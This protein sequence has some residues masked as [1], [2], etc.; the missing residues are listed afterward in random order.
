MA[1]GGGTGPRNKKKRADGAATAQNG[2]AAA[3]GPTDTEA[4][5]IAEAKANKSAK[6][7]QKKV[8]KYLGA[9]MFVAQAIAPQDC[10][11]D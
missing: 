1:R 8:G 4:K 10:I 3:N 11:S 7:R 5:Q 6:I 2:P 9:G